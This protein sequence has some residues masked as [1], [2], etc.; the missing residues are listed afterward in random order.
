VWELA[1]RKWQRR[2]G[3][4]EKPDNYAR[5]LLLA[6]L[7]A[8]ERA[9]GHRTDALGYLREL[10][11]LSPNPDAIQDQIDQLEASE[12]TPQVR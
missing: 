1:L 10:K 4:L 11:G 6:H 9:E 5:Q 2:N 12:G 7:A 8:L 3:G